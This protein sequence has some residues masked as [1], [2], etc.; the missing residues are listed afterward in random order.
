MSISLK[1]SDG[2]SSIRRYADNSLSKLKDTNERLSSGKRINKASDDAAGLQVVSQL[3][4][5]VSVS[6]VATSNVGY[7]ASLVNIAEGAYEQV[8]DITSRLAELATQ[9]SN[10]TLS[11]GQRSALDNEYQA[12][13]TELNRIS[14]TTTFNGQQVLGS[15]NDIQVGTD[16]SEN[17]KIALNIGSVSS[18][19][20]GLSGTSIATQSG[21]QAA[22]DVVKTA[23]ESVSS[24]RAEIGAVEN[25]LSEA[26][27]NLHT[28]VL[29]NEEAASRIRDA[30][31]SKETSERAGHEIRAQAGIALQAQASKV[32]SNSVL[33]LLQ[34]A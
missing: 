10:G 21:A 23:H 6:R 24:S 1:G 22:L 28:A 33:R 19:S 8:G 14:A 5:E 3:E 27:S 17:S 15:S 31:I 29:N 32:N 25:R 13:T 30:D 26:L 34:G 9:A 7:G 18:G 16:L 2:L 11:D 4:A 12:L 20:L